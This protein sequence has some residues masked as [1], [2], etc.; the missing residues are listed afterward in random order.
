MRIA[1]LRPG[2]ELILRCGNRGTA[3]AV[4]KLTGDGRKCRAH[5][6]L[7]QYFFG[8]GGALLCLMFVLNA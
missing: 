2:C 1:G 8:V 4:L 7:L 3:V 5:M 6:P